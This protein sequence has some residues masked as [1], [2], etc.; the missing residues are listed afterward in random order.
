MQDY[1]IQQQTVSFFSFFLKKNNP[2][3]AFRSI[4]LAV[5]FLLFPMLS[6]AALE[7]HI[8]WKSSVEKISETEYNVKFS[9]NLDDDWHT[10]SQFTKEGGPLPTQFRFEKNKDIEL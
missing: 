4:V 6:K 8:T 10:F 9:C 3:G 1:F 2:I 7:Q 5:L